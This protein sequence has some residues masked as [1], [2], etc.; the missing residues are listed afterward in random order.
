MWEKL[1]EKKIWFSLPS[2]NLFKFYQDPDPYPDP[3]IT[4]ADPKHCD[5]GHFFKRARFPAKSASTV[6]YS[7]R[8][9]AQILTIDSDIV[10]FLFSWFWTRRSVSW[11]TCF[12]R[13]L[14]LVFQNIHTQKFIHTWSIVFMNGFWDPV[15]GV[16][17]IDVCLDIP[18]MLRAQRESASKKAS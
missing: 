9:W 13:S 16:W 8:N 4:N 7:P 18:A 6:Q 10:W 14:H 17:L 5:N 15:L 3:H 11:C 12:K 2:E 1:D